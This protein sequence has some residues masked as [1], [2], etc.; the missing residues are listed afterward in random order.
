MPNHVHLL[1]TPA[2]EDAATKLSGA[3]GEAHRRYTAFFNARA[4]TTGHLFQGRFGCVAMDEPHWLMAVRYLAFNPVRA[5][6]CER[7]QDWPWSSARA[8]LAGRDDALVDVS[9]LLAAAPNVS[10]LLAPVRAAARPDFAAE[11]RQRTAAR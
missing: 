11:F 5:G 6:L 10:D 4:R 7:P 9:L 8:H 1:L 2:G 3:V